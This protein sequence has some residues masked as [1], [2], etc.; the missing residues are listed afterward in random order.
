MTNVL[1]PVIPKGSFGLSIAK[2]VTYVSE[3]EISLALR[4][5]IFIHHLSINYM[6]RLIGIM[7][8]VRVFYSVFLIIC[9]TFNRRTCV[10]YPPRTTKLS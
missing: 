5:S 6:C 10:Y 2:R 7:L 8:N 1:Q 9:L 3:M 4:S